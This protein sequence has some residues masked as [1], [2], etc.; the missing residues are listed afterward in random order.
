MK[1]IVV[2]AALAGLTL[3]AAQAQTMPAEITE[4][5][6]IT[7]YNY[8]LASAGNGADA[9]RHL[10]DLFEA[11]HPNIHVEGVPVP[12]QNI[13]TRVQADLVAGQQVDLVQ[14]TFNALGFAAEALGAHALE[15]IVPA[16]ELA[17]N[18]EGMVQNGLDLGRIDGRT[19][20][21]AYTFS[22]P[23]LYYNADIFR[24]V[25]LD[26][27]NPPQTWAQIAEAGR[28]IRDH[29]DHIPLASGMFGPSAGDWLMQG[30]LRS[31]NGGVINADRTAMT[32]A[33]PASLEAVQM[34]RDLAQ[35][36]ILVNL[37]VTS[38]L[39]SMAAGNAA[40]YLQT[41]A[42]QGY[43]IRGADG[44]YDLRATTMPGFGDLR[45]RPNNSGSGLAIFS[46]DPA[47]QRAA[48]ELM[49]FVTSNEGYTIIT[50]DIGYLPLRMAVVESP[51]YLA[52]WVSEHP[53]LQPNL[54][55]LS[56]LEPWTPMPG[57]NYVQIA[58]TMM[59][60]IEM[61]VFGDNDDVAGILTAAQTQTQGLLP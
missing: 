38:Q 15:D 23:V 6:T 59:D 24:Q 27:E 39:E 7:W 55:Q 2:S 51:E 10:I 47:R 3:G 31:N 50:R 9:T 16:A 45:P 53:L 29:S 26:P 34:L 52:G 20:A 49:K 61:A 42:V 5:V 58:T 44:N 14:V 18:F 25:G 1:P 30:V 8:N 37:D 11:A 54:Q 57:P 22:T 17:A 4:P 56:Y 43:L 41:S 13:T 28:V 48:W 60:A 12:P 32:F 21:L 19:Y 46:Q 40:M 33:D 36:G 35:E